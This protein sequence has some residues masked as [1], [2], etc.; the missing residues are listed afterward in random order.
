MPGAYAATFAQPHSVF[1]FRFQPVNGVSSAA[2]F[3][4][5]GYGPISA[6][7]EAG[8][9]HIPLFHEKGGDSI[10]LLEK[11]LLAAVKSDT[12][13][14]ESIMKHAVHGVSLWAARHGGKL[15]GKTE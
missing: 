9:F 8:S 5:C 10:G 15:N 11:P 14:P 1:T 4:A 12:R 6:L 7:A 13:K 2:I 3:C